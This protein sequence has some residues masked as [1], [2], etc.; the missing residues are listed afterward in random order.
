LLV[1]V[2]VMPILG[3]CATLKQLSFERPS[4]QL[5]AIEITGLDLDG[6]SLV[7]WL[8]VYNPNGYEIRTTR[9][10]AELA[11]EGTRFGSALLE[12][13]VPLAP[14]AHTLVKIPAAFTWQGIGA[15]ARSLLDR[16]KVDYDLDARLRVQT[17]LGA[18][19]LTFEHRG[20]VPIRDLVP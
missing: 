15:G 13:N 5:D 18:R 1:I 14:T 11:L 12:E 7:L 17:S 2:G 4:L 9:V 10:D 8:D 20:E 19:T 16:G 3:S 6:V